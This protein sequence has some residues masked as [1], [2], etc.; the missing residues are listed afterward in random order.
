MAGGF[1][2][3]LGGIAGASVGGPVG[4]VAGSAIGSGVEQLITSRK[5]KTAADNLAPPLYDPS[6]QALLSELNQKRKALGTGAESQTGVDMVRGNQVAAN[7]AITHNTGGDVGSTISGILG[8]ENSA[9]KGI[10]QV[11]AGDQANEKFYTQAHMTLLNKI[12]DRKMQ[13]QLASQ[14]Q[15]RAEW[16]QNQQN[17]MSNMQAGVAEGSGKGGLFDNILS[18]LKPASAGAS[19]GGLGDAAGMS[20]DGMTGAGISAGDAGAE[21]IGAAAAIA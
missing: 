4:A 17:G 18:K 9:N 5:N 3:I 15:N 2:S 21:A 11:Y 12:A 6:Q 14:G 13:L 1:G 10:G 20:A 8:A 7:D 16:A 19:G